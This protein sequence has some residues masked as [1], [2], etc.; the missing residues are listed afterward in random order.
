LKFD[1][2]LV[3]IDRVSNGSFYANWANAKGGSMANPVPF[4]PNNERGEVPPGAVI[5]LG[6]PPQ[7]GATGSGTVLSLQMVARAGVAGRG[8]IDFSTGVV[9]SAGAQTI[10]N[11]MATGGLVFVGVDS[12]GS[13]PKTGPLVDAIGAPPADITFKPPDVN[14]RGRPTDPPA[15]PVVPTLDPAALAGAV[16]RPAEVAQEAEPTAAPTAP[17]TGARPAAA[18]TPTPVP[19]PAPAAAPTAAPPPAPVT[20]PT[21]PARQTAA[22]AEP[23]IAAGTQTPD[24]A[25]GTPTA[26]VNAPQVNLLATM[27]V[28]ATAQ[29]ATPPTATPAPA[30][31]PTA[32][33]LRPLAPG[34]PAPRPQAAAPVVRPTASAGLFIPWEVLAGIG[35]G[36]ISA[37]LVLYAFRRPSVGSP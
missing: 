5:V 9:S 19:V 29:A 23:T 14:T 35:G 2:S 18:P 20:E 36:L 32:L 34:S 24:Q 10:P 8:A 12:D 4:R 26:V 17:P 1:P 3:Q 31:P 30:A 25:S 37:G 27:A 21:Q 22:N 6:G 15:R 16:S 7:D 13:A 33:A 11:V 28:L